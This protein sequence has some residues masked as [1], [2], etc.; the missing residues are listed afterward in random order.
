[1]QD[2]D[3]GRQRCDLVRVP[4]DGLAD[5]DFREAKI[6]G[7]QVGSGQS[8]RPHR[9]G[10]RERFERRPDVPASEELQALKLRQGRLRP[11]S[12]QLSQGLDLRRQLGQLVFGRIGQAECICFLLDCSIGM[13]DQ[14]SDPLV[15][16]A[17]RSSQ[18]S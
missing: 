8:F 16:A 15:V 4:G 13:L 1:M 18:S 6:P 12:G 11:G 17:I 3:L 2:L 10:F 9:C 7:L 14:S 5:L